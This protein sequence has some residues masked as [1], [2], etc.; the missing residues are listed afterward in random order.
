MMPCIDIFSHRW[1]IMH[2]ARLLLVCLC[3]QTSVL[4]QFAL[5]S[6]AARDAQLALQEA[7]RQAQLKETQ[8]LVAADAGTAVVACG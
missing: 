1:S 6:A 5:D 8:V 4:V 2:C 3:F 7:H